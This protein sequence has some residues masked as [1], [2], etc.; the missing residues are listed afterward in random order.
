MD[1]DRGLTASST[2]TAA[3]ARGGRRTGGEGKRAFIQ[4]Q[5]DVTYARVEAAHIPVRDAAAVD[6]VVR[7]HLVTPG[8]CALLVD[9]VGLEP[10]F[11]RD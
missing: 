1:G 4:R 3:E 8:L 6:D 5:H 7:D 2:G 9:P 10:V 11:V